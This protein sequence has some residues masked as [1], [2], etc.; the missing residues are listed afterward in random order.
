MHMTNRF[1]TRRVCRI[2]R[3]R[4]PGHFWGGVAGYELCATEEGEKA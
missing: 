4:C 2:D 3:H 1:E